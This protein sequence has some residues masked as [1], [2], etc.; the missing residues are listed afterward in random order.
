MENSIQS[1]TEIIK[2]GSFLDKLSRE[3]DRGA[4]LSTAAILEE[5]LD[6][7]LKTFLKDGRST[8]KLLDGFNAPIGT[9]S[10]KNTLANALG[11]I[12]DIEYREI[13]LLRRI[14]NNFAHTWDDLTFDTHS[15][16]SIVFELPYCGPATDESDS[17]S[18]ART[19]F[20]YWVAKILINLLWR[21]NFI[22]KDKRTESEFKPLLMMG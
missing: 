14:R 20:N 5:C 12:T 13:D 10:S 19:H 3:T 17:K 22:A 2:L 1:P 4:T 21:K 18:N 16:R 11:L 15:I 6:E 8:E 7:I 9:F